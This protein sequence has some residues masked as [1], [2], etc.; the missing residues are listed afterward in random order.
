MSFL[1]FHARR[2]REL[3]VGLLPQGVVVSKASFLSLAAQFHRGIPEI[4][5]FPH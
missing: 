2:A 3:A 1:I 4:T 5:I